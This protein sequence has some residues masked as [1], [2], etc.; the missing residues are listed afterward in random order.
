MEQI[1]P[2]W[3][4]KPARVRRKKILQIDIIQE[5]VIIV[6]NDQVNCFFSI[7]GMNLPS[8]SSWEIH[9]QS[10]ILETKEVVIV[11]AKDRS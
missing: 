7:E 10:L 4:G 8:C 9:L 11:T 1:K 6:N 3:N 5:Q 2:Q